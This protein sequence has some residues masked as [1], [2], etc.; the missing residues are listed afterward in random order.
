M[1]SKSSPVI[2]I[3]SLSSLSDA[4]GLVPA[5]LLGEAGV[6]AGCRRFGNRWGCGGRQL[7]QGGGH[8]HQTLK[9]NNKKAHL[10]VLACWRQL[11][12]RGAVVGQGCLVIVI[13]G[14][15]R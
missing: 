11:V 1:T 3:V 14:G 2:A 10:T 6:G 4:E 15:Q 7:G 13:G 8:C 5:S 12:L 9:N